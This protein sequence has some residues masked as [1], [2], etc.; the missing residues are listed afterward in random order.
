MY[1]LATQLLAALGHQILLMVGDEIGQSVENT[2]ILTL[3]F[4]FERQFTKCT[5][6]NILA[7]FVVDYAGYRS[8]GWV[9]IEVDAESNS[10]TS[11]NQHY[12]RF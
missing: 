1:G 2:D 5:S 3:F 8:V 12:D 7:Y 4:N 6:R 11:Q 9:Q 10:H